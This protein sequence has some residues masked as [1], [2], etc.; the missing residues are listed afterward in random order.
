MVSAI[1]EGSA[2]IPPRKPEPAPV[3]VAKPT[4]GTRRL[5]SLRPLRWT[6]AEG[7]V[8]HGQQFEDCE[9]TPIAAQRALRLRAVCGLDDPRRRELKGARGGHHVNTNALD[10]LDLDAEEHSGIR[11]IDPNDELATERSAR[12]DPVTGVE[13]VEF[14]G[15]ARVGQLKVS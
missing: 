11:F 3:T 14:R 8:R 7:R 4:A 6:D 13:F 9:L 2:P 12:I 5:F 10:L 1:R 15:P